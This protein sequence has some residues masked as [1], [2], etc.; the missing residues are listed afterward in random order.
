MQNRGRGLP[1]PPGAP[2]RPDDRLPAG[3]VIRM[4]GLGLRI[5]Q[6]RRRLAD[7]ILVAF[8]V[9]CE[10]GEIEI[11]AALLRCCEAA[12]ARG[13]PSMQ[14]RRADDERLIA[15]FERLWFLRHPGASGG[16]AQ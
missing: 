2:P 9:A 13:V 14:D 15:A 1:G 10:T 6:Q 11:A 4:P 3:L 5:R 7:R 12:M 16:I 8:H